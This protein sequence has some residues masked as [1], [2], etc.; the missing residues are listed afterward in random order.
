MIKRVPIISDEYNV[1]PAGALVVLTDN[2]SGTA[3]ELS[4]SEFMKATTNGRMLVIESEGKKTTETKFWFE[5]M[6]GC[7]LP[8]ELTDDDLYVLAA[9][10]AEQ[11]KG[12]KVTT[13]GIIWRNQGGKGNPEPK[14]IEEIRQSVNK[15]MSLKIHIDAT[16]TYEKL[17]QLK[18][19]DRWSAEV[20]GTILPCVYTTTKLNGVPN[21]LTIKFLD[22]SPM[23]LYALTK[24]QITVIPAKVL[25]V[26]KTKNTQFFLELKIY[27]NIRIDQIKRARERPKSKNFPKTIRLDTLYSKCLIPPKENDRMQ[28]KRIRD[29]IALYMEFLVEQGVIIEFKF[30]DDQNNEH[31]NLKDCTKITFNY[32]DTQKRLKI[33]D[34]GWNFISQPTK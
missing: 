33:G 16:E 24:G 1:K 34:I 23:F 5:V 29:D 27:I 15:M 10:L 32:D 7:E 20:V 21:T 4:P 28:K 13:E 2:L 6:E 12:N 19:D 30:V 18:K 14:K 31:K 22:F 3:F 26:P 9:C 11:A 8:K 25:N 17:K